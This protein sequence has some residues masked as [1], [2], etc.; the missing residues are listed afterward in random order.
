MYAIEFRTRIRDGIIEIPKEY[1]DKLKENVKVI[2]LS[3]EHEEAGLSMVD[4]LLKS[5]LELHDFKPFSRD[6]IYERK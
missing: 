2:I 6:E 3:E 4:E 5:P 1:R